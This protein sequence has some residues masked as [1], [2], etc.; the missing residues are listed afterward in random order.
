[1]ATVIAIIQ[2]ATIV[3]IVAIVTIH[4]RVTATII[5]VQECPLMMAAL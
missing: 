5:I 3:T 2:T 1:M 4:S